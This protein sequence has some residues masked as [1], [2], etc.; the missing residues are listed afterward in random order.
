MRDRY[1]PDADH[2]EWTILKRILVS[3]QDLCSSF[4]S[5]KLDYPKIVFYISTQFDKQ[6]LLLPKSSNAK[7]ELST[8]IINHEIKF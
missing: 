7:V 8:I 5:R 3:H 1:Q 4:Q 2:H 6:K